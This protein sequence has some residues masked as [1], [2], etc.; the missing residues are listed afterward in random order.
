MMMRWWSLG[1]ILIL[2]VGMWGLIALSRHVN[3]APVAPPAP[4]FDQARAW[5]DLIYQVNAGFRIP[6]TPTHRK[7]REWLV[8]QLSATSAVVTTQQFTHKLTG[9]RDTVLTMW[10]IVA[11]FTGT[12]KA[13]RERV[14]FAAHWDSRPISDQD[15]VEANRKLPIA[16]ANDGASGVAVLLEMARQLSAHPS[17]RDVTIVLFDGE[18][19]GPD[20]PDMLL[21]ADYYATHLPPDNKPDW[22]ILLDMIGDKNLQIYRE[23]NSEHYAKAVDDRIFR[24][25]SDL[26][27][28]K[29]ATTTGFIDQPYK[30]YIDDDH[31]PLIK[32]GVPTADVIDFDYPPWHTQG[33]T[34]DKCSA[35]SL[36]I[37]G[38]TMLRVL[39]Q[40]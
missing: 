5:N 32:A 21:G 19:Y 6:D 31:L 20:L 28:I 39:Q 10:N 11:N 3:A 18:D 7:V 36:G 24:A 12:G 15:P 26:G 27:F 1:W 22:G 34:P 30:Y 25:A 40:N 33:D 4:E 37:V 16:G 14:L 13:P 38:K 29:T 35:E 2:V 8:Q 23:P 17:Q 9:G